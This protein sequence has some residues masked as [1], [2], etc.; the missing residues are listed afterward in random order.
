M[1]NLKDSLN[2]IIAKDDEGGIEVKARIKGAL[3]GP[4]ERQEVSGTCCWEEGGIQICHEAD[5]VNPLNPCPKGGEF[6]LG[7]RCNDK[8][9]C[10]GKPDS[11]D[12]QQF[13]V[14]NSLKDALYK[15]GKMRNLKKALNK[16]YAELKKATR[17]FSKAQLEHDCMKEAEAECD[18]DKLRCETW[19]GKDSLGY[20]TCMDYARITCQKGIDDCNP[21]PWEQSPKGKGDESQANIDPIARV[22]GK[23]GS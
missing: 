12:P 17:E 22:R 3:A 5:E 4:R 21:E 6:H 20:Q 8:D 15:G 14:L 16:A 11:G 19:Y 1:K 7:K 23:H 18:A 9:P 2:K 10:G 13:P